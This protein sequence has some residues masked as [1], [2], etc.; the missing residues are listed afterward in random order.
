[1]IE[2]KDKK[3]IWAR[4]VRNQYVFHMKF[5]DA[6]HQIEFSKKL[7]SNSWRRK[8]KIMKV[9]DYGDVSIRYSVFN[10]DYLMAVY[11]IEKEVSINDIKKLFGQDVYDKILSFS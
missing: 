5:N 4:G 1:M 11:S 7:Y 6:T 3:W 9:I 2:L 10:T 8:R